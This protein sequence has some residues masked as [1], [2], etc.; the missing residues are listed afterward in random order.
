MKKFRG[1]S[2]LAIPYVAGV[3][4]AVVYLGEHYVVDVILGFVYASGAY[5]IISF[6]EKRRL[7]S[8]A[9]NPPLE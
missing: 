8:L 4:F 5:L 3:W 1:L 9:S 2:M 7:A 6:F